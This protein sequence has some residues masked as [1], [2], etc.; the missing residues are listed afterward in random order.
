M[1]VNEGPACELERF[2]AYLRVLARVQ[3]GVRQAK[4]DPS[5]LVQ[6][7][8]LQALRAAQEFR[9]TTDAELAAWLRRILTNTLRNALRDLGAQRRCR[10]RGV[11]GGGGGVV[12]AAGSVAGRARFVAVGAGRAQRATAPAGRGAGGAAGGAAEAVTLH[13]LHG[14]TLDE[15]AARLDR[16]A[17]A[18]A[19]LIKRGLKEL[20]RRL[21]EM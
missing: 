20:H 21:R 4:L 16:S 6:Q 1:G 9:G 5:D 15:T 7:T 18:A 19:G 11:P 10:P 3:L 13:H 14:L 8:L 12:G 2:R 17:S